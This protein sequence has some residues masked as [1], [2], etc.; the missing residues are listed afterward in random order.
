MDMKALC[1]ILAYLMRLNEID[2]FFSSDIEI[3][4]AKAP[5]LITL[6]IE[7][8]MQLAMDFKMKRCPKRITAKNVITLI[9]FSQNMMQAMWKDDDAF[10]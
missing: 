6:M 9:E 3:I 2:E 1:L 7:M 10:L 5:F 4:L 8:T